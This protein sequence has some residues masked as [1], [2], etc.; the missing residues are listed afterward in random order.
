MFVWSQLY[1]ADIDTA[2]GLGSFFVVILTVS[3]RA[4]VAGEKTP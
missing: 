2:T 1:P 4:A 3:P